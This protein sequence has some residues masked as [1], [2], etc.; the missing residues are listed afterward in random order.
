MLREEIDSE[1]ALILTDLSQE[2]QAKVEKYIEHLLDDIADYKSD[3]NNLERE[4]SDYED[5]VRDC[6]FCVDNNKGINHPIAQVV[7]EIVNER[8]RY[9]YLQ[10]DTKEKILDRLEHALQYELEDV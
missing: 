6:T 5:Q 9:S 8:F 3:I 7:D 1:I 4:I 10:Y 2:N